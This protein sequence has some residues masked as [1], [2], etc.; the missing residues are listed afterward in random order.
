MGS[1]KTFRKKTRMAKKIKQN[2][3]LPNW[4][5]YRTDNTI[6]YNARRR[7]WRRT[8]L[9]F[10]AYD[11]ADKA[12]CVLPGTTAC[13]QHLSVHKARKGTEDGWFLFGDERWFTGEKHWA[14]CPDNTSR[15]GANAYCCAICLPFFHSNGLSSANLHL[16]FRRCPLGKQILSS[17]LC[18]FFFFFSQSMSN[19]Y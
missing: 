1:I 13:V 2:R 18:A 10:W 5:R 11:G 19:N 3:P 4:I 6:R 12:S 8:K 17:R 15:I 9:K 14:T 7:H 16:I